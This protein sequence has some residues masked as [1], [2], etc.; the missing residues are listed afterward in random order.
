MAGL[1]GVCVHVLSGACSHVGSYVLHNVISNSIRYTQRKPFVANTATE[2]YT[3]SM[4]V[5]V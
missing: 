1:A 3:Y 5:C 4:S 2:L